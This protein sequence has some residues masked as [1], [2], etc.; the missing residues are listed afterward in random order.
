MK[1][2]IA[3]VAALLV[4]MGFAGSGSTVRARTAVHTELGAAAAKANGRVPLVFEP[5]VGQTGSDVRFLA[6]SGGA[7][8]LLGPSGALLSFHEPAKAQQP[9]APS[10]IASKPMSVDR[11]AMTFVGAIRGATLVP[12]DRL[13]GVS[14]YFI[15]NDPS[16][17]RSNVAQ[18]GRVTYRD[19]YPG[20]DVTFYGNQAGRLEYDFTLSPGVD[21]SVI[22][23][24]F[25][26]AGA[27][28]VDSSGDLVIGLA[29]TSLLQPKP[30]IYQLVEGKRTP[31]SGGYMLD[32]N[33][34]RFAIG[35]FDAM[36]PLIIDPE[37]VY[38]TY[39]GGSGDELGEE[40]PAVD[41]SGSVYACGETTSSDFPVT[42]GVV[43]PSLAGGF[44]GY[45][46]KLSPDGSSV[47]YSTYLGGTGD[48]FLE[49]CAVDGSGNLYME[50]GTTSTDFPTTAGAFQRTFGG[51]Q[52]GVVAKL[53]PDGSHLIYSTYL[54]G[55]AFDFNQ[56]GDL[57]LDPAGDVVVTEGTNS[58]DFPTTP[59]AYQTA[60]PGGQSPLC[61]TP[62]CAVVIVKLNATGTG[63]IFST[64]L[65]GPGA[66]GFPHL[67]LDAAGNVYVS[68]LG[69]RRFPTTLGAFQRHFGGG[70]I[71]AIVAKLDPTGSS[72]IY[73]TYLGGG[74]DEIPYH[75][76]VDAAG[77]LYVGGTTCSKNFP[78]TPG[79]FQTS[80]AGGKAIRCVL[81]SG[82]PDGFITELNPQGTGLVFSTYLGGSGNDGTDVAGIDSVGHVFVVG[83][84][85]STDF[86]VTPDA[87]QPINNGSADGVIAELSADGSQLLFSTYWGGTG[88]DTIIGFV[89]D[90]SDNVYVTGCTSST[91]YPVT[92][93]AFQ[94]SFGGGVS[95]PFQCSSEPTDAFVT[96]FALG[97]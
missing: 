83:N 7:T 40:K 78:V 97:S 57:A 39:L 93:G 16:A 13:P 43:Q 71:D 14:N 64:Y 85:D 37:V 45:I 65:G 61:G 56:A 20:V 19:L 49:A 34:L 8:V 48:D 10:A 94:P 23:L 42:P 54:G 36:R 88:F 67:A 69:D 89:L 81:A 21:P 53:S 51:E 11:V 79:A 24:A 75:M 46:T 76:A 4:M 33:E 72:L 82:P 25:E 92:P 59:G 17:W 63:L 77:D 41:S 30:R 66:A 50:G 38:S 26:G 12:Q 58:T 29:D 90:A 27:L 80:N 62:S 44:D 28:R 86:P 2:W 5:N 96:K 6:H 74:S 87:F 31:I 68:F 9:D 95:N 22:R 55:T 15:G 1:Q 73:A 18:Y 32:G 47:V 84:T 52:D 35:R 70:S 91:D 60:D 3:A